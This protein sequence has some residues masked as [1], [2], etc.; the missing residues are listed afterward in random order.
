[1]VMAWCIHSWWIE[2]TPFV[3]NTFCLL[4]LP[5]EKLDVAFFG[6]ARLWAKCANYACPN[7]CWISLIRTLTV[8]L[9]I[10]PN[11]PTNGFGWVADFNCRFGITPTPK[12]NSS[13]LTPGVLGL[14]NL[15]VRWRR[16]PYLEIEVSAL[17]WGN[18]QDDVIYRNQDKPTTLANIMNPSYRNCKSWN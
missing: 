16:L 3:A 9:G 5:N 4:P 1:M 18:K 7:R 14:V 17:A 8:G 10:S 12:Y 13:N 15:S 6:M 2:L 11:P